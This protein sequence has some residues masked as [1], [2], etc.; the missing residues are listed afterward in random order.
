MPSALDGIRVIDATQGVAGPMATRLL[1]QMGA[2]VIKVER[3]GNGDPVRLWDDIVNGMASGHAWVNPGKRSLALDLKSPEGLEIFLELV[4]GAD[5]LIENFVP[6]TME[7]F[8][9]DFDQLRRDNPRLIVCRISGFGQDGPYRDRSALDLIIQGE[10]GLISTNGTPEQPAK[11]S[12]SLCDIAGSMYALTAILESL[13]HRERT[14]DGQQIDL[15]LFDAV[16]TW[17]GY[18][19]YMWWYGGTEPGRVGLNHH[20]MFPYGAYDCADERQ[21]IVAAGAGSR[22]QWLKFCTAIE[23]LE[24]VDDPLYS[25]N[26][27]RI[28]NKVKLDPIVRNAILARPLKHWTERFHEVGIPAGAVNEFSEGL[29]HPRIAHRGFVKDV[30][31]AVGPVKTFDFAPQISGLDS[32]NRLGPP[33]VGEHSGEVLTELGISPSRICAL[34]ERGVIQ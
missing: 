5:V 12:V 17:T 11:I 24:L 16:M 26:R 25:S 32:V 1:A 9:I 2:D 23:H 21:V 31:S 33:L 19:P 8:G 27:A 29:S 18:F 20:T 3:P 10:T 30:D 7:S 15:A 34:R 28:E 4:A 14:G 13:Y 22:E 6:G